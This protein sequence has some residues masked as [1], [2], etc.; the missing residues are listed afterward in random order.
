MT[1]VQREV[2]GGGGGGGSNQ[3]GKSGQ[4]SASYIIFSLAI[5]T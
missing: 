2:G 1:L 3:D 5:P 4:N